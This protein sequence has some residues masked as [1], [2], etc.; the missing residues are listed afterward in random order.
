MTLTENINI[1]SHETN[2]KIEKNAT[3]MEYIS[4]SSISEDLLNAAKIGT[5]LLKIGKGNPH[6][7]ITAGIHGN[8]LPPQVA[9]INLIENLL[10]S[11]IN[12][13]LYIIPFAVPYATMQNAR[14]FKGVD[15]NRTASK[16]GFISNNIINTIKDLKIT[17]VGDF[18]STKPGSNPGIESVFCSRE[19]TYKSCLIADFITKSTSSKMIRHDIA[20]RLYNGALEDECNLAGIP[21]VT[22][23]VVSRNGIVDNNSHERSYLQMEAYLK[24][25]DMI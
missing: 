15:M 6:I 13:T 5:P 23:E 7:M 11:Q 14:R 8:E 10:E 24:Y 25:F 21:A 17:A 12:G 22:C 1:I 19:P 4:H 16:G 2:G 18:H 9:A 3:L 20:G